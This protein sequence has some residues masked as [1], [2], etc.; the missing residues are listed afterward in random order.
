MTASRM[1]KVWQIVSAGISYGLFG[2]G[3]LVVGIFFRLM[4]P[5]TFIP[6]DKKQR[7]IR[8]SIHK[9]CLLFIRIMRFFGLIRYRF[10]VESMKKARPGH[11]I[12]ANHPSLIDVVLLLA[13][14]EQMCCFVKSAVWNNFFTGAVVRQ[15]GFIPNDAEQVLP[16][17]AAKLEAGENILIF[18]EG[19]RTKEDN[20]IRF[21]RGAANMAVAVDAAIMPVT[22]ECYPRALKKGDKWYDI[23][24]GGPEFTLTSGELLVLGNCIDKTQPRPKQY[25]QLTKYLE[26]YYKN[27]I[28]DVQSVA[29]VI[30]GTQK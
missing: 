29:P 4:S 2:L 20:V 26:E 11:I 24:E 13:V 5:V 21:K 15:A 14:N 28:A 23:P 8:W 18:P 27:R 22:I 17:A 19:T 12:I 30:S 1:R 3:A 9:G 6:A 25:R 10:H 7:M 16:M